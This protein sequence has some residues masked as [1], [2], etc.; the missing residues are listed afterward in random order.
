MLGAPQPVASVQGIFSMWS[1]WNGGEV[2]HA[3]NMR[4]C[5]TNVRPKSRLLEGGSSFGLV[6][7]VI[8]SREGF[9]DS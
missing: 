3:R 7:L 1:D 8:V 6:V 2:Q 4:R 5:L 9:T